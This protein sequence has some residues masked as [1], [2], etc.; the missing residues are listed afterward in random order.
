MERMMPDNVDEIL[1]REHVDRYEY[2]EPVIYGRVLDVAC[3][4]GYG[5]KPVENINS[6]QEYEGL[7]VSQDAI[8]VA[9]KFYKNSKVQFSLG[10]ITD[11]KFDTDSFD[12][13]IS[14]ETLE[15]LNKPA[16]AVDE[17]HRVLKS[18]G[19]WIGSVP[20]QEFDD[21]C[22]R[23]YGENPYHVTR[24]SQNSLMKLLEHQFKYVC[25]I[26][27]ELVL[28]SSFRALQ[29]LTPGNAVSALPG[30]AVVHGSFAFLATNSKEV[31]T[32]A[33]MELQDSY[34]FITNLVDYDA[35]RVGPLRQTIDDVERMV[36]DRDKAIA[37][38]EEMIE[39]RDRVINEQDLFIEQLKTPLS[40]IKNLG[41]SLLA[42]VL[43]HRN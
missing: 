40:L 19:V 7:D 16:K 4:I 18:E 26:R 14:F 36:Q 2:F 21:R 1:Y 11:I 25:I 15:H 29:G 37:C 32:K 22:E 9:N 24:F 8:D 20:S 39:E 10:D 41:K 34:H 28:S 33:E 3:G 5:A 42:P 27:N 6:V 13:A 43:R 31:L 30:D 38:M 23:V 35:L 17:I 12:T